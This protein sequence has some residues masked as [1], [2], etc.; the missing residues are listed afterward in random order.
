MEDQYNP[1][2]KYYFPCYVKTGHGYQNIIDALA[3]SCDVYFY[4]IGGGFETFS[5][6]GIDRL[7]KYI[8]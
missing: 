1:L 8:A 6:L 2:V 5:G 3:N 4:H 7:N